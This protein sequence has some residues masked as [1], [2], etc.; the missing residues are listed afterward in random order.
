MTADGFQALDTQARQETLRDTLVMEQAAEKTDATGTVSVLRPAADDRIEAEVT[1]TGDGWVFFPVLYESGWSARV[2]GEK[3]EIVKADYG[4]MA[5]PVSE[6]NST[7]TLEYHIPLLKAGIL[8]TA[9]SLAASAAVI[10]L[11]RKRKKKAAAD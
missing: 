8:I 4:F 9:V 5:L 6:G 7:V 3:A 1:C 11:W 2:N 10:L